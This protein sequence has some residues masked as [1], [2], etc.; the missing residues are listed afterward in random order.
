MEDEYRYFFTDEPFCELA[1]EAKH[2]REMDGLARLLRTIP[3]NCDGSSK[4]HTLRDAFTSIPASDDGEA[5]ANSIAAAFNRLLKDKDLAG[6]LMKDDDFAQQLPTSPDCLRLLL[7]VPQAR[8]L[9]LEQSKLHAVLSNDDVI[10]EFA[11]RYSAIRILLGKKDGAREAFRAHPVLLA[12]IADDEAAADAVAS[13]LSDRPN[14]WWLRIAVK[15]WRVAQ[16]TAAVPEALVADL[17]TKARAQSIDSCHLSRFN[18]LLIEAAYSEYVA[19]GHTERVLYHAVHRKKTAAL[20]LSGGGIRSATFNLGILQGLADHR[21]LNRFHYVS[22]VSGGGYVGSWLSSWIRRHHEGA[23][24]VANDLSREAVDPAQPEVKPIEHLREYSS[25]LAPRNTTFSLDTW[26]LLATYLRNLFLNWTMLVPFLAGVF[27]LPRVFEALI[28]RNMIEPFEYAA[29]EAIFFGLAGVFMLEAVRPRTS[30]PE[31]KKPDAVEGVQLMWL[32]LGLLLISAVCFCLHW[33]SPACMFRYDGTLLVWV[34]GIGG[35]MGAGV[36]AV[37]RSL[38]E[39]VGAVSP[40]V[41]GWREAK[42]LAKLVAR[43]LL[44]SAFGARAEIVLGMISGAAGGFLLNLFFTRA[45]PMRALAADGRLELYVCLA[46]PLFLSVFFLSITLHV[47]LSTGLSEDYDREWWAR[48]GAALLVVCAAYGTGAFA[49]IVLPVLIFQAPQLAAPFGGLSAVAA[50]LSSKALKGVTAKDEQRK[51]W[52]LPL[53]RVAAGITLLFV[54]AAVSILSTTII[55]AIGAGFDG[56]RPFSPA[57]VELPRRVFGQSIEPGTW[58]HL[59]AL[60]ETTWPTALLFLVVAL[61][62]AALMSR[63]LNVNVYSMHGMYRDRLIRAYLGA[64]RWR[65]CPDSFT[66]FD[67]QDDLKM[68]ELRP[69]MLWPSCIINFDVFVDRLKN[70][71]G[72]KS[73]W[74]MIGVDVQNR[75]CAYEA[76]P[77]QR[78]ILRDAARTAVVDELNR[79]MRSRDLRY[80]V[81][82]KPSLELIQANRGYIDECFSNQKSEIIRTFDRAVDLPLPSEKSVVGGPARKATEPICGRPP[83]HILNATLNLVHGRNLAWQE[84]KA[85]SFTISPLHCGNRSVGYRD[86]LE[87]AGRI[88][89]GSSMAISGAA[90]S[91]NMGSRSSPAFTCLMALFNARLGC[92]LGNPKKATYGLNSPRSSV[93]ALLREALGWTDDNHNFVFLSDGGHFDNLGLYEMVK[94]RCEFIVVCDATADGAYAFGDLAKSVRQIRIDL[95]IPIEPLETKYIGPEAGDEYGKYCAIGEIR[96]CNVDSSASVG[97]LLYIK[98]CVYSECP[99]DV[100]NY[101]RNRVTFPHETTADQFFSESQFESY[102]ALGRYIIGRICGDK[103]GKEAWIAGNMDEFFTK[104]EDY[105]AA[106]RPPIRNAAVRTVKDVADWMSGSFAEV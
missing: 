54:I 40:N 79:L 6:K 63:V 46:I 45:F 16:G 95:G 85:D 38:W 14:K 28:R 41:F 56:Q 25:Y 44:G 92:W 105:L 88:S 69:E 76:R 103:P 94:R 35:G 15:F 77:E 84:R 73:L 60:R 17:L 9:L 72:C 74:G 20:C 4:W 27:A 67:P 1:Y 55:R 100:R 18:A 36:F 80:D 24:G 97:R 29:A 62:L 57:A 90:V 66:G 7:R 71:Q 96:Y 81:P 102:R 50:Y 3:C 93:L 86:S 33:T 70:S 48:S 75:I 39:V 21:L 83:L 23:I 51:A 106:K 87:Y 13:A 61:A 37:R 101:G 2:I 5:V 10:D 59:M 82:A 53:L 19:N 99:P 31:G 32:W 34:F 65:R 49:V 43:R 68:D 12:L 58:N 52:L 78:R 22:T 11:S 91:P 47:G 64:S 8:R 30:L 104:A 89:L 42:D 26:T 98:P